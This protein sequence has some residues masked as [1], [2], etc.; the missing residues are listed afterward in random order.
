M[1]TLTPMRSEAY[2]AFAHSAATAYAAENVAAGRWPA[3]DALALAH[4]ETERLLPQG[5]ATPDHHLFE[6]MDDDGHAVGYIWCAAMPRGSQRMA[7]VFQVYIEP[8]QRRRGH[9]R[10]AFLALEPIAAALG[11]SGMGLHVFAHNTGAQALYRSLGYD[12]SSLNM[13]KPLGGG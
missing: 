1:T 10:A 9:A 2:A 12:V 3:A 5:L 6:V 4:A 13:F 11:L 8:E 7:F